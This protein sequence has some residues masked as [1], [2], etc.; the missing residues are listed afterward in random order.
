MQLLNPLLTCLDLKTT[1]W[2]LL[3]MVSCALHHGSQLLNELG[4]A[5]FYTLMS[6]QLIL[7]VPESHHRR[8]GG[9]FGRKSVLGR[10][11][12]ILGNLP[13]AQK[14]VESI[15][16]MLNTIPVMGRQATKA[17]VM[18]RISSVG[19]IHI[20]AHANEKK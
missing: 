6:Y 12:G 4:F 5:L 16:L 1:S 10:V 15:A 13:G 3:L 8:T 17:E 19:V 20:A 9:P 14:E 11:G 2:S 7:S 18:N